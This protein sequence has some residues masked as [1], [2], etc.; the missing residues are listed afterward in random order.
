MPAVKTR[1]LPQ[2]KTPTRK[3]Q[4]KKTASVSKKPKKNQKT[5]YILPRPGDLFVAL[6][7]INKVDWNG[8]VQVNKETKY[9]SDHQMALNIGSRSADGLVLVYA[10]DMHGAKN[11]WNVINELTTRM[12]LDKEIEKKQKELK[13]AIDSILEKQKSGKSKIAPEDSKK[14]RRALNAVHTASKNAL[15]K[16]DSSD[17]DPEQNT[18]ELA[19]LVSLGGWIEGLY[20]VTNA[21]SKNYDAESAKQLRQSHLVG[22]YEM[23]LKDFSASFKEQAVIKSIN[24]ALP[25]IKSLTKVNKGEPVALENVKKLFTIAKKLKQ[26]IE[27]VSQ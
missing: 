6:Q 8:L 12:N 2:R 22:L 1:I 19:T 5:L 25:E 16:A 20:L 15:K 3:L 26:E 14:L 7:K 9:P 27:G 23:V 21:L 24:Q 10:N 11:V 4:Q 18:N 17:N 13:A